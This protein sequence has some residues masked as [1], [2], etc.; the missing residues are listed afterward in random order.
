[1]ATAADLARLIRERGP[2]VVLTGAGMST[3]SGIP[4]LRSAS[5]LWAE[6]DPFEVASI[7]ALR[8]D[9]LRVWRWYGPRIRGLLAAEPNAGHL[10]LAALERSGQVAAVVT[11]NIDT[12]HTRAGS[13]DVVEVHGSISSS[14]C[15][16]CGRRET[17]D[18]VLEQLSTSEA[19]VCA[20]CGEIVKPGVVMF[21]E[22]LPVEAMARAERL[23][24][25]TG[26]LVVVGSS[27]EVWPVAGLPEQAVATGATLAILN[28]DATPFDG[29]ASL[30]VREPA[31][32]TLAAVAAE[33]VEPGRSVSSSSDRGM[34]GAW[35]PRR[36]RPPTTT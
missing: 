18:V 13:T 23:V 29:L 1:M 11:Q 14:V 3:E 28:R 17:L 30:V 22:L 15:L 6:V 12:L 26:L 27:L 36:K 9:P 2:A 8:R 21:G 5:G 31:G 7:D 10:A 4:D 25:E 24:R 33:L 16:A 19:P 20:A 35:S 32:V 34:T